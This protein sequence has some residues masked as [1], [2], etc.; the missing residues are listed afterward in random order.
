MRIAVMGSGAIGLL[1]GGW[2]Q[3]GGAD[4]TF[5]ARG[6]RLAVMRSSPLVAKGRLPFSIERA[7]VV[8]DPREV[9]PVDAVLLAVK[10]YDLEAAA[11]A[12]VLALKPEG[13]LI[14]VQNGIN[15]YRVLRSLLPAS[16]IA[17]GPVYSVTR[18][19]DPLVLSYG[20]AERA[21]L[22]NPECEVSPAVRGVVDAWKKAGVDASVSSEIG[23][24]L[25][26]KFVGLATGAAINCLSR[27]PA[28]V[29]YHDPAILDYVRQSIAEV[30]AVGRAEG[31]DF[32]PETA[33]RTLA[34]LQGFPPTAVAS[35]RLDL[36]AGKRLELDGISGEIV[37]LGKL[38]NVPTPFHEL[39]YALLKPFRDGAPA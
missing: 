32:P 24:V 8:G 29:V 26:M 23:H 27:L 13:T 10:L 28:G 6:Q 17:V 11:T 14:A 1:Y 18:L 21:V 38:H 16:R 20:G 31:I 4:V 22:G 36:D 12:S 39:A 33:E 19:D 5:V 15:V 9:E 34:F 35:M 7:I 3:L 2:L 25:W 37:R 30:I